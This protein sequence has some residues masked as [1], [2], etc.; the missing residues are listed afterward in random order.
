MLTTA[1]LTLRPVTPAD[2]ADLIALEADPEVMFYLNG[3]RPVPEEGIFN[4]EYLTP[5]GAE[6]EV[7]AMLD[8]E[9]GVFLGWIAFFDD[10]MVDGL[11]RSEIGYRLHQAAWGKGLATEAAK[12][13]IAWAF[14]QGGF[15]CVRASTMAVNF[16][17]RRV[18]EKA[19]MRHVETGFPPFSDPIP[20]S[21]QG[22]VIYEIR[23]PGR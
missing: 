18:M 23:K 13:L 1:R 12:A 10:G 2:R 21:D 20:G 19:G 15:D 3:G 7:M 9:T 11:R 4:G 5:R 16:G 22:E 14:D 8:R 17:S 6:P